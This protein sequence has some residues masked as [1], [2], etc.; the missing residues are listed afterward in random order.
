MADR[1]PACPHAAHRDDCQA[2][3]PSRCVTLIDPGTGRP[4]GI[5]CSSTR[6]PCPC[7][8]G[9]CHT[10][11]AVISGVR[12]VPLGDVE[13]DVDGTGAHPGG[14]MAVWMLADGTLAGRLLG[15][16]CEP[17]D[18]EWRARAHVHQLPD[19]AAWLDAQDEASAGPARSPP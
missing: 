8:L 11:G 1:C 9:T 5:A 14:T 15:A 17:G 3:G 4:V 19:A 7:P 12:P 18:G 13:I 2:K 16:W 6:Q 10:C